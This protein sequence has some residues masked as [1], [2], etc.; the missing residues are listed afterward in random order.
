MLGILG[1]AA[2]AFNA[3]QDGGLRLSFTLIVS[4]FAGFVFLYVSFFGKYPWEGKG[5][6]E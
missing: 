2:I 1:F 3:S 4:F 5:T 6:D